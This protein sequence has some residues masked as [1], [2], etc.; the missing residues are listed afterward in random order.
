MPEPADIDLVAAS[1]RA[2]AS[3]L[4]TFVEVLAR[5]LE[6][7]FG[8]LCRVRRAGLLHNGAVRTIAVDLGDSRYELE[9]DDGVVTA[10]RFSVV[11]G[12]TLKSEELDLEAWTGF[13]A[14][15][16]TAEASRTERGRLALENLLMRDPTEEAT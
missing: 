15:D 13:L 6:R 16:A 11:R 12:I 3:D 7:A 14:A 1:L 8:G 4:R 10:R 9:H 5:K 2:D